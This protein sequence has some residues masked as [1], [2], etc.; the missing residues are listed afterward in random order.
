MTPILQAG[1]PSATADPLPPD[2]ALEKRAYSKVFWR[3]V[4]F[5]MLCYVVAYL[6]RVNVGFAKL[7]MGQ[8]LGFSETV[9]GLG[10]G[11]FFLGYFLFEVPSNLLLNRVG[12]RMWI[13]RIMITWA[14][15]PRASCSWKRPP[16]STSCGSCSAWPRRASIPA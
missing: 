2:T 10:A 8:D 5:L 16:A 1:A 11:I 13:A 3:L 14:S 9:F 7:Q 15:S 6:D 4:P 12:A